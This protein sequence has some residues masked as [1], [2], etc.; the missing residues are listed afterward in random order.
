[1]AGGRNKGVQLG[2][3]DKADEVLDGGVI[4]RHGFIPL[5]E[6]D[7]LY[8]AFSKLNWQQHAYRKTGLAPRMYV[9]MGIPYHS[10]R[11]TNKLAITEWTAEAKD[12]KERV[13]RAAR[14]TFDSLNFNLYR[15]ERDSIALHAD[16][17]AEGLWSYPIASVSLGAVRRFG[18]RKNSN[19]S[20]WSIE[21]GHGSLLI[22]PPGFQR[23]YVHC[24]PKQGNPCGAR[25]NLTFRHKGKP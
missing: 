19:G 2:I 24:V 18:W 4:Y 6:A 1:M 20:A 17:E 8:E 3:F 13:E 9:W 22:M 14:S 16:G 7:T 21:L 10:P 12:V 23:D 5:A 11:L 15:N 25:I